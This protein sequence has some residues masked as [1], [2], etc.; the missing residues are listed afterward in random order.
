MKQASDINRVQELRG[1]YQTILQSIA[2]RI[3]TVQ[4][5]ITAVTSPAADK[6]TAVE[7]AKAIIDQVQGIQGPQGLQGAQ[8]LVQR[9]LVLNRRAAGGG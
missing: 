9:A 5:L 1:E 2:A 7:T 6:A 3:T 8:Q 4:G